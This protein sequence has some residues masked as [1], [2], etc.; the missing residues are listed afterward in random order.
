MQIYIADKDTDLETLAT[1]LA[2]TPR[3]AAATLARVKALNPHLADAARVPKGGVLVL[4]EGP[5][6][7]PGA[8]TTVSHLPLD[9]L[10]G[11]FSSGT[12]AQASRAAQRLESLT[13]DRGAVRD[14]LKA[15][16]AKRL[17]DNDPLLQKQLSAADAQFK[18][19]QK[20]ATD[21]RAEIAK[22][23]KAAQA[24]LERMQKL[25]S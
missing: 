4:P 7:K 2:R 22:Q 19:E 24:E 8:G 9:E 16:A 1:S 3:A 15:A 11:G 10:A 14:A 13:A 20:R 5:D 12:R 23:A 18:A 17:V 25:V 21:S 6:I